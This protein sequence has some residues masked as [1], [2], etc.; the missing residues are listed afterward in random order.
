[1]ANTREKV[2]A[3][4]KFDPLTDSGEERESLLV[5]PINGDRGTVGVIELVNFR[6]RNDYGAEVSKDEKYMALLLA[7]FAGNVI[8]KELIE[9]Y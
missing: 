7:K 4:P 3:H 1:M 9:G 6:R 5:V 2:M 8:Q